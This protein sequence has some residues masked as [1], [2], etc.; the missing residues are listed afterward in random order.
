MKWNFTL[1][2]IFS[3]PFVF[4]Q[5]IPANRLTDWNNPGTEA[6]FTNYT[7]VN[8]SDYQPDTTGNTDC[9]LLFAQLMQEHSS[10]I[11]IVFPAGKFLFSSRITL[12]DSVILEGA[13]DEIQG[14]LSTIL[15]GE[16]E[17]QIY[18]ESILNQYVMYPYQGYI[19]ENIDYETQQ[20]FRIGFDVNTERVIFPICN[21]T[22]DI[23]SIK[24]RTLDPAYKEK[25]LPKFLYLYNFNN[26]SCCFFSPSTCN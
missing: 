16:Q 17:N 5:N 12:R 20:F 23:I 1:L 6:M 15:L 2:F 9:S 26:L 13:T 24:G 21:S 3:A 22:G 7:L 8:F 11:K 10:P 18:D 4:S 19:D 14:S 25:N